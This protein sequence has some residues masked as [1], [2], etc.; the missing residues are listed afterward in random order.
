MKTFFD[1]KK[2]EQKE[3]LEI[4][5]EQFRRL[6]L[7][8]QNLL[9]FQNVCDLKKIKLVQKVQ[10]YIIALLCTGVGALIIMHLH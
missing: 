7:K 4:S 5:V 6:S 1:D 9:I 8:E 10:G 3:T 2:D